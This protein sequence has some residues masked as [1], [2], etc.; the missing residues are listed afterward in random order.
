M[1]EYVKLLCLNE[2]WSSSTVMD[3]EAFAFLAFWD[4]CVAR[5]G[6]FIGG[7]VLVVVVRHEEGTDAA[8]PE[9]RRGV[10]DVALPV[11]VDTEPDSA[12][13]LGFEFG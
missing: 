9:F 1:T 8:T 3:A 13:G 12:S 6:V 11:F 4:C 2:G 7:A 10:G 5:V